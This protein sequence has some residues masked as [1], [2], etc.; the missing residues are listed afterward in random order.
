MSAAAQRAVAERPR[1]DALFAALRAE[2]ARCGVALDL[3]AWEAVQFSLQRDPA[4][5]DD[6]LCAHWRLAGRR[7]QLSLR[8]DGH[9]WAECDL[10][11][12]HPQRPAFWIEAVTAWGLAPDL[13]SEPRLLAKPA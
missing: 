1:L 8:P 10:L 13:K 11:V 4:S 2:A 5:G 7:G 12:D 6:A 3:P 9:A